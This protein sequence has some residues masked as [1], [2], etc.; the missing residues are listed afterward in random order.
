MKRTAGVPGDFAWIRDT[1]YQIIEA[2]SPVDFVVIES[3]SVSVIMV[4]TGNLAPRLLIKVWS[5][6]INASHQRL[7]QA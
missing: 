7:R 3:R 2:K 4:L 1:Q 5:A 6:L